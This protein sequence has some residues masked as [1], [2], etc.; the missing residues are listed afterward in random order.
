[1]ATAVSVLTSLSL[2]AISTNIN[3]GG[4]GDYYLISRTLGLE[5][6]GAIGIV[7]FLAQSVSIAFYAIGFGEAFAAIF[8]APPGWMARAAAAAAV[9]V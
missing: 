2:A 8:T 4:G 6:S 3:V 9:V 1:M 5:F 7:L